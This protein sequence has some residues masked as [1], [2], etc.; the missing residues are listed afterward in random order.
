MELIKWRKSSRSDS[1]GDACVELAALPGG[2]GLR[3]SKDPDG[4]R[5]VLTP[6]A[7]RRLI[8]QCK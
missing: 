8:G 6:A 1:Q 4:G 3:D 5:L 7:F 2:V